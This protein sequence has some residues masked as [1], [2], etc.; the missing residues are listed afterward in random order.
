[1]KTK[2]LIFIPFAFILFASYYW[3]NPY[4]LER[5]FRE[6]ITHFKRKIEWILPTFFTLL[7]VFWF[8]F[9]Y[10]KSKKMDIKFL[11][12]RVVTIFLLSSASAKMFSNV[13][14]Y[15][16]T[17]IK[18]ENRLEKYQIFKDSQENIFLLQDKTKKMIF[19]LHFLKKIDE[20]R[21]KNGQQSIY[22]MA[23]K[24]TIHIPFKEGFLGVKFLE[25]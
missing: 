25:N 2:I 17:K 9:Q 19:F 13:F 5:Y 3:L 8:G 12:L 11:F 23:H 20:K 4:L 18:V 7:F 10:L 24:D 21:Q 14:L 16:N 1:M 6:D 15:L 22:K